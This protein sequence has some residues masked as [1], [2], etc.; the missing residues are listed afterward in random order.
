VLYVNLKTSRTI[1]TLWVWICAVII[2][3]LSGIVY[4][5]LASHLKVV[6]GTPIEL[7]VPLSEFPVEVNGWAGKDVPIPD[8]I[9]RVAKNDDFLNRLYINEKNDKWVNLY[10]AYSARPRTTSQVFA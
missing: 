1:F 7:P 9:Q 8:N 3:L 10:V 6:V 4:R 5:V 2:I